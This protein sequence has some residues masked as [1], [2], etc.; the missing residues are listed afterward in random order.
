MLPD[1]TRVVRAIPHLTL[2]RNSPPRQG[3]GGSAA[4][5][6]TPA[7]P[8]PTKNKSYAKPTQLSRPEYPS[9]SPT[10][11]ADTQISPIT[12]KCSASK[13]LVRSPGSSR[14]PGRTPGCARAR[15]RHGTGSRR[16]KPSLRGF[17]RPERCCRERSTAARA[18]SR[19]NLAR[20]ASAA[21][22]TARPATAA[23]SGPGSRSEPKRVQPAAGCVRL[24][25]VRAALC[26]E[27]R[28]GIHPRRDRGQ[29]PQAGDPPVALA[30]GLRVRVVAHGSLG[31]PGA[32]AVPQNALRDQL[33]GALPVRAL[34]LLPPPA[35]GC[36]VILQ[37][38]AG[39]LAGDPGRQP[40]AVRAAVRAELLAEGLKDRVKARYA[41]R[42]GPRRWRWEVACEDVSPGRLRYDDLENGSAFR[43]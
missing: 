14:C 4:A 26:A 35:P 16:W 8:K 36:R 29:G 41:M 1:R 10:N 3:K 33:L 19:T 2:D 15:R 42:S 12:L 37:P 38:G 32:A 5:A 20:N 21:S 6:M 18:S 25:T 17:A 11:H 23:P 31:A 34:C 7:C 43:H 39:G 13:R 28:R 22:S 40:E 24:R 27:R 30:Q 9:Q